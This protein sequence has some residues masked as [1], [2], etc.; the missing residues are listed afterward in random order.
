MAGLAVLVALA[1]THRRAGPGLTGRAREAVGNADVV[2]HA[3]DFTTAAV[4]EALAAE[5]DELHAVA[6]NND[7]PGLAER[8]PARTVFDAEGLRVAMVHGHEHSTQARSLLGREVGADL[9]VSGHSHR[10]GV[11]SAPGCTLLNPG[12]HADPRWS[13]PAHAELE[14]GSGGVEGRLVEPDGT[15]FDRFSVEPAH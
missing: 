3:G 5:C 6:G 12:S 15:V 11:A 8:L 14:H 1:D 2:A 9:V 4:H 10:P 7:E 13:R